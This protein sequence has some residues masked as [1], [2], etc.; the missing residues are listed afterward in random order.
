MPCLVTVLTGICI[1]AAMV[2]A[3]T[4]PVSIQHAAA[5]IAVNPLIASISFFCENPK[6]CC[7][8]FQF[9]MIM[10][11]MAVYGNRQSS[12]PQDDG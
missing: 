5:V 7:G 4:D 9:S 11:Q 6:N 8:L 1:F 10:P 3:I 2:T 12:H